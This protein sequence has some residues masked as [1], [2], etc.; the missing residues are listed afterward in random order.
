M[1]EN[2]FSFASI[3]IYLIFI[4]I[5]IFA[6]LTLPFPQKFKVDFGGY[7]VKSFNGKESAVSPCGFICFLCSIVIGG[8]IYIYIYI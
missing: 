3:M 4:S 5:I 1:F 6:F 8:N 7:L 2:P